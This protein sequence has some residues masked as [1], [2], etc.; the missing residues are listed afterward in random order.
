MDITAIAGNAYITFNVAE[1]VVDTVDAPRIR[2]PI[3]VALIL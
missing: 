3:V 2:I 1:T